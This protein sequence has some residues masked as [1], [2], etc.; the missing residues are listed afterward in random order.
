MATSK[1]NSSRKQPMNKK[2]SR[3][4]QRAQ[5]D[6]Q[7]ADRNRPDGA[8]PRS[9][10][11]LE[12]T[13]NP[14][15]AAW[16]VLKE[17]QNGLIPEEALGTHGLLLGP[18]DLGLATALVYEV[19]R[20]QSYLDWLAKS[21]LSS[22]RTSADVSLTLRLGLAQLLF[23]QRLGD[24]AVV[25]ETVALAKTVIPGRHGLVNAVLRGLLR[26]RE[27][28]AAWPPVPSSSGDAAK[29]LAILYSHQT[30][31]VKKLLT[32]FDRDETEKI[33]AA[34]N[35]PTPP[36]LRVNPIKIDREYLQKALPFETRPTVLS[37]WGLT[38]AGFT[39]RPENWP[40]FSEGHF[41]LQDEA[42]QLAA[43]IAGH[44]PKGASVLDACSGLGGKA[45][46]LASV[47]PTARITAR[48]KDEAKLK[49]LIREAE[50]LGCG[51][52]KTERGDLLEGSEEKSF[53]LVVV[54]APCS[55]LG[56][57]RR[58]PDLK[59]N[60]REEDIPRL[61][62]LQLKLLRAAARSVRPGGRLLY[63][64]CSFSQEEGPGVARDF[65]KNELDFET[66]PTDLWPATLR[67]QL[68]QDGHLS[69][70]P[71]IHG[72]DGFFWAYFLKKK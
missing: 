39:G 38:S 17:A 57:I 48:D 63:G 60:K 26:D 21:R 46:A 3:R 14:R 41:A 62:E 18:K 72:T 52:I 47:N 32:S 10:H 43:L 71:H 44:L 16:R 53:D 29:D 54:D 33:L 23:F 66:A 2:T 4:P 6:K 59:W 49:L 35:Q 7:P 69:L 1:K 70:W 56:V 64:V 67:D 15:L 42:S 5:A 55:G 19:L 51:N 34:A 68:G 25:S 22:G 9:G 45:L 11:G 61:A 50:R 20:H 12:L 13:D 24:H 27:A 30:W 40:G 28:G 37:P 31:Q 8:G 58:R 36:T 65:L